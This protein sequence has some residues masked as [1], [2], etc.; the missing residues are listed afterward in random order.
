MKRYLLILLAMMT[1]LLALSD[2]PQ[3]DYINKYAPIA[4]SE[5]QRSGVPA[6]ITLAQGMLESRY[7]LSSLAADGNNH[8]GIKC[9]R[10]WKGKT[11]RV[12]DDAPNECFR[13]YGSAEESFRDHSDFLRYQDRYK[14][15]FELKPT[16]YKGW[17]K[18]LK[19]AGYATDPKYAE[20][21]IKI[22]EDYKLYQYDTGKTPSGA[23]TS[24][25]VVVPESPLKIEEKAQVEVKNPVKRSGASET[26]SFRMDRRVYKKNGILCV[27]AEH[28]DTYESIALEF[29]LFQNEILRY[30]DVPVIRPLKVGEV[31]YL[32][33]KKRQAPYGLPMYVADDKPLSLWEVSQRFGVKMKYLLKWNPGL[34]ADYVPVEGDVIYLKKF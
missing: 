15:L 8:F 19:K 17:A 32:K 26:Y 4:V 9:H 25:P 12:N 30:N 14:P 29:N 27:Y 5:M 34:T 3:N 7:G 16:D 24:V 22:I 20:K 2:T 11:M 6:S 31:V 10:N 18:G 13:V 23:A 28:E 21:L 33:P 1:G